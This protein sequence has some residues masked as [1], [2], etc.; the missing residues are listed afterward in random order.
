MFIIS[1]N[2]LFNL[3]KIEFIRIN[4]NNITIGLAIRLV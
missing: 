3:D 1:N 4:K 2:T